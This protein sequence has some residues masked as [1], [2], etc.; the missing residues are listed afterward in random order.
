MCLHSTDQKG[1]R[2]KATL[3][4]EDGS[5]FDGFSFG[6]DKSVGGE[7]GENENVQYW[8]NYWFNYWYDSGSIV[9]Q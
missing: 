2:K 1:T 4:L 7:I 3:I 8:F 9:V 6:A 5:K